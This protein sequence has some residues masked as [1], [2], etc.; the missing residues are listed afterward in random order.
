MKKII[1]LTHTVSS[2]IPTWDGDCGF[3]L[4][5]FWDYKD[6]TAPNFF[7]VQKIKESRAG[8]G[9]HIDAP[10]HCIE[11]GDAIDMLPLD[12]LVRPCAVISCDVE[13]ADFQFLP[14]NIEKYEE[15]YGRIEEGTFVIFYSG[16]SKKWTDKLA[17]RN[18][19]HFPSVNV[20]TAKLLLARNVS[21]LGIDTL[22]PDSGGKDFPVHREILG[23]K[24][25]IVENICH[26]DLLPENGATVGIFPT[27][28]KD[29][30]EAPV[31]LVAF[32]D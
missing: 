10:A 17:Y 29:A 1:D 24:K 11:G 26:A 20:E 22:S 4:D 19:L 30:T 27:K 16:W 8:I 25:Y 2:D 12:N 9:T 18:D 21:G 13:N 6:S 3:V 28:I 7:R 31:R 23:A 5:T 14:E 32:V 15:K